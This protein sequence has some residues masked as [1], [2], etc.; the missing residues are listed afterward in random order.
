MKFEFLLL[1]EYIYV[2]DMNR[3]AVKRWKI[4]DVNW[5]LSIWEIATIIE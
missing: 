2:S 5:V 1:H 4:G 3:H